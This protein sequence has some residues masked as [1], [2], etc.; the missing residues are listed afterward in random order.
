L[1]P[2]FRRGTCPSR[3]RAVPGRRPGIRNVTA[4][5]RRPADAGQRVGPL[6]R[7][8]ELARAM[9][10]FG[11]RPTGLE[12]FDH[13]GAVLWDRTTVATTITPAMTFQVGVPSTAMPWARNPAVSATAAPCAAV[14][15][16]APLT[17]SAHAAGGHRTR[18]LGGSG[19]RPD[20]PESPGVGN[21]R[22]RAMSGRLLLRYA[23]LQDRLASGAFVCRRCRAGAGDHVA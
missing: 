14:C 6:D 18:G 10:A 8:G 7:D 9:P 11:C 21:I 12:G 3:H 23:S 1:A 22:G 17:S 20:G 16:A 5:A 19:W 2:T 4:L 15:S 13:L